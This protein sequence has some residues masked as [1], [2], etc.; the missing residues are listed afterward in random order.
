MNETYVGSYH[1]YFSRVPTLRRVPKGTQQPVLEALT[2]LACFSESSLQKAAIEAG[3]SKR[4]FAEGYSPAVGRFDLIKELTQATQLTSDVVHEALDDLITRQVVVLDADIK[5]IILPER[6]R[7]KAVKAWNV[8]VGED[9]LAQLPRVM[10]PRTRHG[11][12]AS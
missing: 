1:V 3:V 2:T 5:A 12:F 11:H 10:Y 8:R 7:A 4:W 6:L 9:A